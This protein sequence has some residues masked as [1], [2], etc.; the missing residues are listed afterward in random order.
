LSKDEVKA[1]I[2]R[3]DKIVLRFQQLIAEKG[4]DEVLY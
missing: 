2:A 1:V 3:R 4:S